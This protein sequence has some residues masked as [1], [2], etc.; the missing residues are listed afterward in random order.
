ME[1]LLLFACT[2]KLPITDLQGTESF[3]SIG[4]R[5]RLIRLLEVWIP[6]TVKV[7]R[8]RQVSVVP[9]SRLRHVSL[10]YK[11]IKKIMFRICKD[12]S[13]QYSHLFSFSGGY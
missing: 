8:Q 2:V 3:F 6:G 10:C 13:M 7:F 5:F 12:F 1:K 4:K 11:S 9:R